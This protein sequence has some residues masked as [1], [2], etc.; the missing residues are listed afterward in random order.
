M[1]NSRWTSP[2]VLVALCAVLA[3][4]GLAAH[5]A[6]PIKQVAIPYI[7]TFPRIKGPTLEIDWAALALDYDRLAFDLTLVGP[8]LP[9]VAA[10]RHSFGIVSY[11][12]DKATTSKEALATLGALLGSTLMGLPKDGSDGDRDWLRLMAAYYHEIKGHGVVLNNLGSRGARSYWYDIFPSILF[13]QVGSRYDGYAEGQLEHML[14]N[15]ADT[16]LWAL[17]SINHDWNHTGFDFEKGATYS[18]GK[19]QEPDAAFGIGYI[20]YMAYK[21]LGD[22]KYLYG[23]K[24]CMFDMSAQSENPIYEV[25]GYFGPALAAQMNAEEGTSFDVSK[26]L[27]FVFSESSDS[28][29]GW[30]IMNSRWGSFNAHGLAGSTTD[31]G[32]Y[33]FSMNTYVAV[34]AIAPLVIHAPEYA[35][36]IGKWLA[37]VTQN[38]KLF[39]PHAIPARFQTAEGLEWSLETG[40]QVSFEGVRN[41]GVQTPYSTGD[42]GKGRPNLSPYGAWGVG[43]MGALIEQTN[44]SFMPRYNLCAVDFLSSCRVPTYLLYN[45]SEFQQVID[46]DAGPR[47]VDVYDR[48]SNT[49]ILTR[50][51]GTH[52][53]VVGADVALVLEL[54]E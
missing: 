50:V 8:H 3:M 36:S 20:L 11:I 23:A 14:R 34:L 37:H 43:I 19:W 24:R 53:V 39:L 18:N 48:V 28:R 6:D 35:R 31:S 40:F 38:A 54:H 32:G 46:F 4:S 21:T 44:V 29:P 47:R 2:R 17:E 15:V 16:W 25:L 33:A 12:G 5:S 52:S 41:L 45:N 30:G 26:F 9:I 49:Y 51:R 1:E 13:I 10:D 27:N 22:A 7:E 42:Q